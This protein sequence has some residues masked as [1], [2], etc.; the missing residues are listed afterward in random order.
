MSYDL[1]VWQ[2]DT[3]LSAKEALKLYQK[4]CTQECVPS[5]QSPNV[6]AFYTELCARYPEI[7]DLPEEEVDGCPWSC[8]HDKSGQHLIMCMNYGDSLESTA[9]WIIGL[10]AKHNLVCFDPQGT[11]VYQP[12]NLKP[13][14]SGFKFW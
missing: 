6:A 10:A 11:N 2:W 13:K 14:R 12:P 4:L 9:Q 7:D 8:A 5:E 3:E 1:A